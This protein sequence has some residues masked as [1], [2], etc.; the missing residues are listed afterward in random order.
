MD[1]TL[2]SLSVR[3]PDSED[4]NHNPKRGDRLNVYVNARYETEHEK[5]EL[6]D[7]TLGRLRKLRK[8][9]KAKAT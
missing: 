8:R 6:P 2:K 1:V 9:A 5:P 3:L 4:E 7:V